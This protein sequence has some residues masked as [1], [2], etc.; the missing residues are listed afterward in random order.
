MNSQSLAFLS[1]Y[2]DRILDNIVGT[3]SI[4]LLQYDAATAFLRSLDNRTSSHNLLHSQKQLYKQFQP[5]RHALSQ[6]HA[7]LTGRYVLSYEAP[8]SS[9]QVLDNLFDLAPLGSTGAGITITSYDLSSSYTLSSEYKYALVFTSGPAQNAYPDPILTSSVNLKTNLPWLEYNAASF[10]SLVLLFNRKRKRKLWKRCLKDIFGYTTING[11][12]ALGLASGAAST[13]SGVS[14]KVS[15]NRNSM[16]SAVSAET[17]QTVTLGSTTPRRRRQPITQTA[18]Q[19]SEATRTAN[20]TGVE[21]LWD[22]LSVHQHAV[23]TPSSVVPADHLPPPE[24]PRKSS[25][26]RSPQ[27][28]KSYTRRKFNVSL[29]ALDNSGGSSN[30]SQES[31]SKPEEERSHVVQKRTH[32][33]VYYN[34]NNNNHIYQRRVARSAKDFYTDEFLQQALKESQIYGSREDE[35]NSVEVPNVTRRLRSMFSPSD[36][37]RWSKQSTASSPIVVPS[38]DMNKVGSDADTGV[39]VVHPSHPEEETLLLT[40]QTTPPSLTHSRSPSGS[41]EPTK[42]PALLPPLESPG[43]SHGGSNLSVLLNENFSIWAPA[44]SPAVPNKPPSPPTTGSTARDSAEFEREL[45]ELTQS[46]Q[47]NLLA[48]TSTVSNLYSTGSNSDYS[49]RSVTSSRITPDSSNTSD[50]GHPHLHHNNF[51]NNN[52]YMAAQADKDRSFQSLESW[53]SNQNHFLSSPS[54]GGSGGGG[55][56][57]AHSD[58]IATGVTSSMLAPP[59]I[60]PGVAYTS[61]SEESLDGSGGV[62]RWHALSPTLASPP[63]FRL[64]EIPERSEI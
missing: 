39:L 15:S 52:P 10:D 31:L 20:A 16:V 17:T 56:D 48:S 61:S 47:S 36:T 25:H 7:L 24:I 6:R 33:L 62:P 34:N 46:D 21:T 11:P 27:S 5:Q 42:P 19:E 26:R 37:R 12:R 23:L 2:N 60:V 55:F 3:C 54:L 57:L 58:S 30:V 49:L 40:P 29:Q 9:T 32:S 41:D 22:P 59:Q 43:R 63:K 28:F 1:A 44:S 45:E 38:L 51:N 18:I 4:D 50:N 8:S 35:D 64:P 53:V 13:K 14:S